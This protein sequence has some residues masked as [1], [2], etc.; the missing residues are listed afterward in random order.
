MTPPRPRTSICGRS[1]R[2]SANDRL[3]VEAHEP[4]LPVCWRRSEGTVGRHAGVVDEQLDL[5]LGGA[6]QQ[7]VDPG[8]GREIGDERIEPAAASLH[9]VGERAQALAPAGHC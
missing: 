7:R 8:G 5:A 1:A 4:A 6:R 2:V 9:V 3:D